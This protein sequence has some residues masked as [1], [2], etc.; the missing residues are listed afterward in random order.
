MYN[1]VTKKKSDI[2]KWYNFTYAL[3]EYNRKIHI[4]VRLQ[5]E[6]YYFN[7]ERRL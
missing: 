2:I 5:S 1:Y 3:M 4:Y 6:L 7:N